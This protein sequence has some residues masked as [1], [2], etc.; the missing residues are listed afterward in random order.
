[1]FETHGIGQTPSSLERY[2]VGSKFVICQSISTPFGV[3]ACNTY[4]LTH[5]CVDKKND[6]PLFL[7]VALNKSQ[8]HGGRW[9]VLKA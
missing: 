8:L 5:V 4:S 7:W 3:F 2:L 9:V 6:I 1:M